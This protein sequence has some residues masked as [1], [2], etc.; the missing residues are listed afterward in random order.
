MISADIIT[1]IRAFAGGVRAAVLGDAMLDRYIHGTVD[2]ISPEAPVPILNH[3]YTDHKAGGA[4][5]VAL[6]LAAWGCH[7]SLIGLC[8]RDESAVQLGKLLDESKI[9]NGLFA[10]TSRPTTVKT[11]IV[12]GTHHLLRI[13]DESTAYLEG[14]SEAAAIRHTLEHLEALKP[15]LIVMEDYNKGYL[16]QNLIYAVITWG[17]AHDCFIAVDP[18]EKHF[19]DYKHVDLFKPNLREASQAAHNHLQPGDLRMLCRDWHERLAIGCI[20]ITLGSNGLFLSGHADQRHVL[21]FRAIDVIDVCGAGDA[22]I[23]ALSL[24]LMAGLESEDA[25]HLSN[26]AGAF[27]CAHSGVV[28]ADPG[29]LKTWLT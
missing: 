20:A 11:R 24:G 12:A 6:N 8:G 1:R 5:N 2:R 26:A 28:A 29:S 16:T 22:V 23:A 4:A 21:P 15:H 27:V 3:V 25:G 10:L 19:F 14:E 13:D 17:K 7:T 18:K 9:G